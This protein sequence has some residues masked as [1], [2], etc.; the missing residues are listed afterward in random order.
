MPN[1][2]TLIKSAGDSVCPA[3]LILTL[4]SNETDRLII[5]A[6]HRQMSTKQIDLIHHPNLVHSLYLIN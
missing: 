5:K 4:R 1:H 3:R 6:R 2:R